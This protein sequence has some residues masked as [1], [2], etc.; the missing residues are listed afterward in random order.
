MPHTRIEVVHGWAQELKPFLIEAVHAA[1]IATLK[2]PSGDRVI[3]IVEH[4]PEDF[5]IPPARGPKYTL[6]SIDLF[7]GRS[8]ATK[9]ALY[10]ALVDNLARLGIP[11]DDI[12]IVLHEV[13]RE[14][15]GVR[16]G[17]PAS[18]I[19]LGFTVEV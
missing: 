12:H 8:V 3:R 18:E 15:W 13:P 4:A 11:S 1:Q 14:N 16:G 19:E 5:A 2:I 17:I 10:R 7:S 9:R 6:V